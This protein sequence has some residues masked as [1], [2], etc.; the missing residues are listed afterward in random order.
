MTPLLK[1]Q[2][3]MPSFISDTMD[4]DE[5]RYNNN[6][7]I[8]AFFTSVTATTLQFSLPQSNTTLGAAVNLFWFVS[9]VFGVFASLCSSILGVTYRKS[10]MYV[11]SLNCDL[12]CSVSK[13]AFADMTHASLPNQSAYCS[14]RDLQFS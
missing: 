3:A 5:S 7:A 12:S 13:S 6:T 9:V 8:A 2:P 4:R 1:S 10:S 14:T 11:L